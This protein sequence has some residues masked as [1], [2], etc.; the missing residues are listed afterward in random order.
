[1]LG[2]EALE[3][4]PHTNVCFVIPEQLIICSFPSRDQEDVSLNER[5]VP[6]HEHALPCLCCVISCFPSEIYL[7]RISTPGAGSGGAGL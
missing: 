7:I 3:K 2:N 5:T 1:M 6:N 4:A